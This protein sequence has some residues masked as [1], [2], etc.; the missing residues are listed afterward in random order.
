MSDAM[1]MLRRTVKHTSRNPGAVIMTV[2]LPVVL[3]LLFVG[4]FGGSLNV[5]MSEDDYIQYVVAGVLL[6]TVGYGATTT[7]LA[8][9]RDMTAGIINRFRTMPISR[10]SVLTGHVL[11]SSIRTLASA[12]LVVAVA[13]AL[14]FRGDPDPAR[15]LAAAGLLALL[16]VALTWLAVAVGLAA[17]TAEG[18]APFTLLVQL[19][20]F[21]SSAFV[22][23]EAMDGAVRWFAGHEPFTPIIDTLRG[24][25]LGSAVGDAWRSAV[26]WCL[27]LAAGGY[28]WARL[29]FRRDPR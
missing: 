15:W 25:L 5:G 18:I 28:L 17:R 13:L 2:G 14:G 21:L 10:A 3:L 22:R 7:A 23:P 12:T 27:V 11:G 1:T 9:N 6:M 19:L 29:L 26:L 8:V 4:V 16:T 20:P 24:L